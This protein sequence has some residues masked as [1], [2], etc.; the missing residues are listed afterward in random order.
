MS[1]G[2]WLL[3]A[4]LGSSSAVAATAHFELQIDARNVLQGIQHVRLSMPVRSG[5]LTLAY[6][7]WI[8][9]EHRPNGPITQLMNLHLLAG[10]RELPWRRDA[11]D[12][13][14]FH[15]NI[16]A[17][18]TVLE[19][20]FDYFSP[21][22]AFGPGF[23]KTPDVTPHLLVLEFNDFVLYPAQLTAQEVDVAA[24]VLIPPG[25]QAD[26]ALLLNE[27]EA[28]VIGL[29][30]VSL[31]TLVDSPL[32]AGEYFRSVALTGGPGS[33]RISIAA[34]APRDLA[35]SDAVMA[36]LR[37]LVAEATALFGPGHYQRYVWLTA[38]SDGLSHDGLEH[39]ESS[40]IRAAQDLFIDPARAID[41][42]VFPHEYVHS[43]NGKYRR[44]QGLATQSYQ[45]PMNDAL[46]W[47]YEGVTRYYGDLVLA[48]RSGLSSGEET[49]AYVA[50]I[51]ALMQ[52]DRPGRA[53][54]SVADTALAV[55]DYAGAPPEWTSIR[56]SSDYY[57]EGLLLWLDADTMIRRSSKGAHCLDDFARDFFGGPERRPAVRPYS[58]YDLIRALHAVAPL[59][60]SAFF[61]SRVDAI[62][63]RAPLRGLHD[64]GWML[65]YD[66][67]PSSF[68]TALEQDSSVDDFSFSLGLSAQH[69][70]T[71]VDV[72]TGS[73]AFAAGIAPAMQIIAIA[74]HRWTAA[75]ARDA[76]LAA[77]KTS[78]PLE[79]VV[80]S[81]DLVRV[82]QVSYHG[83]LRYPHL[84]RDASQSDLLG[85]I[86]APRSH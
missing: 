85:Q 57:A 48:T 14:L 11:M 58:R 80:A 36:G 34:D 29:P 84:Q 73:P 20:R 25:W 77:Q 40:D 2:A 41:W 54:R 5:P 66:D 69:D 19:A 75:A 10:S 12:G 16:P 78:T 64:S 82:L 65:T 39:H 6:P 52:R 59:D 37:Q 56:R 60:W 49:R 24:Q 44:P 13:F 23:G 42:H 28:G 70:G 43:W 83:G 21:P 50:Y 72:I 3:I 1:Q 61:T 15:V 62:N 47:V 35:A 7:R 74:G 4:L 53:W 22:R 45:Q 9:G 30:R 33:T 79:L 31:S 17:G 86:L 63:A 27:E 18:A 8:P 67:T 38:L 55:P 51:A 46:L 32:L 68:L 71:V 26:D 76:I 81:S